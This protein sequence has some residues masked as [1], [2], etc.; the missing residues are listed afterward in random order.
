MGGSGQIDGSPE[1]KKKSCWI[2][3]KF[4]HIFTEHTS[5]EGKVSV[6]HCRRSLPKRKTILDLSAQ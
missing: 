5:V 4:Q 2:G 1:I 6:G 3:G